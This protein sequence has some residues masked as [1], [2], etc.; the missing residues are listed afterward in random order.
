MQKAK[1]RC[2][3]QHDLAARVRRPGQH[4]VCDLGVREGQHGANLRNQ[5]FSVEK[6][7]DGIQASGRDVNEKEDRSNSGLGG[8]LI[9]HGW[10]N[11]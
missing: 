2:D 8:Y 11:H 1:L 4:F 5:L 7:R 9:R 10:G 6:L 3:L